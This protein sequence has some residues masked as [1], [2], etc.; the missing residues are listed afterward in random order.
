MARMLQRMVHENRQS[1]TRAR[2]GPRHIREHASVSRHYS[3][4]LKLFDHIQCASHIVKSRFSVNFRKYNA[5]TMLPQSIRAQEYARVRL[6]LQDGIGI[7]TGRGMNV[8]PAA[9]CL[10]ASPGL[11]QGIKTKSRTGLSRWFVGQAI[12][13]PASNGL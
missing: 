13:V 4:R 6:K 3:S 5:K 9:T 1:F 7:V 12:F 2:Q 8:P 10:E 11:Q